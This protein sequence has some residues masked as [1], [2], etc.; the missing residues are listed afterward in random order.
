[1]LQTKRYQRVTIDVCKVYGS[2]SVFLQQ[3]AHLT[4][5]SYLH[6][7]RADA[8]L[9]YLTVRTHRLPAWIISLL[10]SRIARLRCLSYRLLA[11]ASYCQYLHRIRL[12]FEQRVSA[13]NAL[14]ISASC[15]PCACQ[16]S[17][18]CCS[19]PQPSLI[20]ILSSVF[21]QPVPVCST[22]R[23]VFLPYCSLSPLCCEIMTSVMFGGRPHRALEAGQLPIADHGSP[24]Y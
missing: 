6:L 16:V 2:E 4:G 3:A 24:P 7:E 1:M 20:G 8:L 19:R 13:T 11:Y 14:S 12:I 18:R 5:G 9:Q 17:H 22:C 10:R 23:Q 21:C 15:A